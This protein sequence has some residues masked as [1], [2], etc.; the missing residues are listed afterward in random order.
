MILRS[1]CVDFEGATLHSPDVQGRQALENA[2]RRAP[3]ARSWRG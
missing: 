3:G 2:T 1:C